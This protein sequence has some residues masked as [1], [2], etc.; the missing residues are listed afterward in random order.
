MVDDEKDNAQENSKVDKSLNSGELDKESHCLT[1]V[2]TG[3]KAMGRGGIEP[4][5]HGFS[6]QNLMLAFWSAINLR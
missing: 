2:G 6:V 3:E 1:A 5:T 4:P